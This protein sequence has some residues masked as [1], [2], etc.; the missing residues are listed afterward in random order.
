MPDPSPLLL[1]Q[2]SNVNL[3]AC[4]FHAQSSCPCSSSLFSTRSYSNL[5]SPWKTSSTLLL[6]PQPSLFVPDLCEKYEHKTVSCALSSLC[7]N[8]FRIAFR[9]DSITPSS[10]RLLLNVCTCTDPHVPPT[11]MISLT[12]HPA[13]S[14]SCGLQREAGHTVNSLKVLPGDVTVDI[15]YSLHRALHGLLSWS[16][17]RT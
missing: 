2:P 14:P 15:F 6:W 3:F 10:L 9:F 12:V 11:K 7:T 5:S 1:L 13:L 16:R 8:P 17:R 4:A